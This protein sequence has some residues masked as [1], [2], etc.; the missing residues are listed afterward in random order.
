MADPNGPGIVDGTQND[1]EISIGFVD[2]DGDTVDN[3]GNV[4]SAQDG[5]DDITAGTGDDTIYAGDDDDVVNAGGGNDVIYGDETDTVDEDPNDGSE[6][7]PGDDLLVGEAGND[8][9]YGGGGND[10]IYGDFEDGPTVQ[11]A[12]ESFNWS[13]VTG[14]A[15]GAA[16]PT[17]YAQNTGSVDVTVST[18]TSGGGDSSFATA[19]Q[20][21]TDVDTGD[22]DGN[23]NSGANLTTGT[24]TNASVTKG[25]EFSEPVDNVLFRISDIDENAVVKV[26][27]WDEDGNEIEVTMYAS[28]DTNLHL[29]DINGDGTTEAAI[30]DGT[31]PSDAEDIDNS[32]LVAIPGPVARME[33]INVNLDGE[34]SDV[35]VSDVFFD[36]V[37][38]TAI[39]DADDSLMGEDGDDVIY[40]QQGD[41]TIDGGAGADTMEGGA[42]A[43]RFVIGS[44]EEGD[45]DVILGGSDGDD[46]DVLQLDGIEG[47]D[48]RIVDDSVDSDGNGIDGTVE[49]LDSSGDEPYVTGTATFENIEEIV[50]FTPGTRI[51][52]PMGEVAVENLSE[53]D[54]VV[55]RDNGLQTIRW[56]GRKHVSGRD[57]MVRPELRPILI[58]QGA[59]GPNQPERDMM[60]SPSHR[61]LL[62]SEQAELLFEEREVLVA[63]KHLTHLDGVEQIDVVG[64]DYIH[65]LCDNHEVVLADGAW[66]ESFQPGEYSM[67][68]I[69]K[70]QRD[71]IYALFPEL[72]QRDGLAG[73]TAARLSLKRHEAKL[74]G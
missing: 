45:G 58:K 22:E 9:I 60:V 40:G 50:C 23:V 34:P 63:A 39:F 51:L 12:R 66:S 16:V 33:I 73:Y 49:F 30:S 70:E 28:G 42:D 21:L 43:D 20:L 47:V 13:E 37:T 10:T 2:V 32:V 26:R 65:F 62:V 8:T 36:A 35:V 44:G 1:D 53:G 67:N 31:N 55:T 64:V 3:S 56:S 54:Q 71:E 69:G 72:Q 17:G 11:G 24:G 48:W 15:D 14:F 46:H 57:L 6:G 29:V 74:L 52:T 7:E 5:D 38:P 4:I 25:V 18:S 19:T 61:M 41:D 59:L 27:A 68:G